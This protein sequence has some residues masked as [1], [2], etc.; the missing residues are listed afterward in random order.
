M[1]TPVFLI[2]AGFDADAGGEVHDAGNLQY[3]LLSDLS[4]FF[5]NFDP[6]LSSIEE[7]FSEAI[8]AH[9]L[10]PLEALCER[11]MD[12]DFHVGGRLRDGEPA[13]NNA[14]LD[15]LKYFSTAS[16]LT[17]NYDSLLEILLFSLKRWCPNDLYG[18]STNAVSSSRSQALT[19]ILH[20]HGS[21]CIWPHEFEMTP[22]GQGT[23]PMLRRK[24][25]P[26]FV[27]EPDVLSA[28][29]PG[30]ECSVSKWN[31]RHPGD[32]IIAP[33]PNKAQGLSQSFIKSTYKRAGEILATTENIIAIGYS[34]NPHDRASYEPLL[35]AT[36]R[37]TRFILITP[38]ACNIQ[39]RLRREYSKYRW[40]AV[41][42]TFREWANKRFPQAYI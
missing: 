34:F 19:E 2:G 9:D 12:A 33:I 40:Q 3:P 42:L 23:L 39:A 27:F 26:D 7:R 18:V 16:F 25:P 38:D 20:L 11:L 37:G 32:R 28:L 29:F 4:S 41:P 24:V 6:K 5:L 1:S 8:Q 35:T 30:Y 15:F 36:T 17:F 14:Y 10:E 31:Y 22:S 13:A 21:F